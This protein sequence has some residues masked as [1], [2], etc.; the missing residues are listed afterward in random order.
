MKS[1][2]IESFTVKSEVIDKAIVQLESSLSFFVILKAK[3]KNSNN[4]DSIAYRVPKEHKIV[5][6]LMLAYFYKQK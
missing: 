2:G 4:S 3:T 1:L 5:V 6:R